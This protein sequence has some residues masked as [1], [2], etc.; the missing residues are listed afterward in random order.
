MPV[1]L[2]LFPMTN[3]K[4]SLLQQISARDISACPKHYHT[5]LRNNFLIWLCGRIDTLSLVEKSYGDY[6]TFKAKCQHIQRII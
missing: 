2:G 5:P 1:L 3:K 6:K 4:A